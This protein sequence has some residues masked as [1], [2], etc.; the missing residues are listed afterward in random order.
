[1]F[2][3]FFFRDA[4]ADKGG[5]IT[6]G[7]MDPAH[8]KGDIVWTDVTRKGYWQMKVNRCSPFF[9]YFLFFIFFYLFIF[10]FIFNIFLFFF[11]FLSFIITI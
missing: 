1:M 9:I 2:F 10:L 7:G 8:Y 3:F 11:Y 6:F 4:N 5:E